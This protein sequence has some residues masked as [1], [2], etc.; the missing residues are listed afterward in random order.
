MYT[1][2]RA[3]DINTGEWT[4][5][6]LYWVNSDYDPI[7]LYKNTE[8]IVDK[9]TL[10]MCIN[11]TDD[12]GNDIYT[13]DIVRFDTHGEYLVW[14]CN[15][16]QCLEA[17]RV[18]HNTYYNKPSNTTN[19]TDWDY[20]NYEDHTTYTDFC[21]MLKDPYGDFEGKIK[22]IGNIFDNPEL[23]VIKKDKCHNC[24]AGMSLE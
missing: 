19:V 10:G 24:V 2:Y 20:H 17:V 11:Y 7:L 21:L 13:G 22:V 1:K 9:N 6:A 4:Y 8:Y 16:I 18:D 15:E 14:F 23:V 12:F 3:K 5:G